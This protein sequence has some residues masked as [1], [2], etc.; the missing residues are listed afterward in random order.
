MGNDRAARAGAVAAAGW[1]ALMIVMTL[2]LPRG[3][4]PDTLLVLA[5]IVACAV[6]SVRVTGAFALASVALTG[7]SGWLHGSWDTGQQ[8]V[9]LATVVAVGA[10]AVVVAEVRIRREIKFARVARIAEVA[11]RAV[12]PVVPR[13]DGLDVAT[14]YL[15]ASEDSFVGGDLY[16]CSLTEGYTRFIVGDVRGKGIAAVEQAARV[17]RAFRQAAATKETLSEVVDDMDEYLRSFFD[18]EEFVTAVIVDVSTPGQLVIANCGHPPA[19]LLRADGTA[20]LV[21][22]T[23]GLP[24]GLGDGVV[25]T[26]FAWE[27]GDRL[28]LYTD[29]LAEARNKAGEFFPVLEHADVLRAGSPE[30]ALDALLAQVRQFVPGGHL[31]DDLAALLLEKVSPETG[32]LGGTGALSSVRYDVTPSGS[33]V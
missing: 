8:W 17:I 15:S 1:L 23:P 24:L 3:V 27:V 32:P 16:D 14:R 12:L 30:D 22:V 9:G 20:Q 21:E 25:P 31:G 7:W 33:V 26:P 13:V 19:L 11:Q 5:P 28:L 6:C 4:T 18:D 10:A 2:L 29:G